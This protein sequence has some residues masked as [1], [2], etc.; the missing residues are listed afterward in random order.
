VADRTHETC[1]CPPPPFPPPT[2]ARLW[3]TA[4]MANSSFILL[5]KQTIKS[6]S[7]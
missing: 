5:R 2:L 6:A 7:L 4:K 1:T 3:R